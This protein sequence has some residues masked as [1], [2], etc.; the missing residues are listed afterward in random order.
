L[1]KAFGQEEE[2]SNKIKELILDRPL[3]KLNSSVFMNSMLS[4]M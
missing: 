3:P 4:N 1:K 2:D